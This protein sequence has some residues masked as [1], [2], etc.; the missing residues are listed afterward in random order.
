MIVFIKVW[1]AVIIVLNDNRYVTH[2]VGCL[3]RL[4]VVLHKAH[5]DHMPLILAL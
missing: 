1:T 3:S 5:L 4:H 2:L